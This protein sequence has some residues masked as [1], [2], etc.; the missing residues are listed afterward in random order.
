MKFL[1]NDRPWNK[2]QSHLVPAAS[3]NCSVFVCKLN[4]FI[5]SSMSWRTQPNTKYLCKRRPFKQKMK[6]IDQA[7][8]F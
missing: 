6:V 3:D 7:Q 4:A 1:A 2:R 5:I 8:L